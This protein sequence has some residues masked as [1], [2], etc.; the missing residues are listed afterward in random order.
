M[1]IDNVIT[2]EDDY[3]IS[4]NDWKYLQ[5]NPMGI[6][7]KVLTEILLCLNDDKNKVCASVI[8]TCCLFFSLN[9]VMKGHDKNV[10]DEMFIV[11]VLLG[12][13]YVGDNLYV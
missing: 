12:Y 11:D 8:R 7:T 13:I 9:K 5:V 4:K 2:Q 3:I 1:F 6:S 10:D